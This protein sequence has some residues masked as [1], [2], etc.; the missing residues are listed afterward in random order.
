MLLTVV[1]DCCSF[2]MTHLMIVL[3]LE[4]PY[5]SCASRT[6]TSAQFPYIELRSILDHRACEANMES[7]ACACSTFAN[8]CTTD[9]Y[10]TIIDQI[11]RDS[12][13]LGDNRAAFKIKVHKVQFHVQIFR[14]YDV[15]KY[16]ENLMR[17]QVAR[18]LWHFNLKPILLL[19]RWVDRKKYSDDW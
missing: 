2:M 12:R 11:Q 18:I 3:F 5:I 15:K 8:W 6:R 1:C 10:D 13:S 16:E 17:W 19:L 7:C 4:H 9:F 14:L